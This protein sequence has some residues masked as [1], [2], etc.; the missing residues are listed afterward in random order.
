MTARPLAAVTASLIE[1]E[2]HSVALEAVLQ[3]SE[4]AFMQQHGRK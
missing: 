2:T 3:T 4:M 1:H